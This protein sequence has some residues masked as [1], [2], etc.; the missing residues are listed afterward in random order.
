MVLAKLCCSVALEVTAGLAESNGSLLLGLYCQKMY[1]LQLLSRTSRRAGTDRRP[2]YSAKLRLWMTLTCIGHTAVAGACGEVVRKR[3]TDS[4]TDS[5]SNTASAC[6][7][8]SV[9]RICRLMRTQ[10]F[11]IRTPLELETDCDQQHAQHRSAQPQPYLSPLIAPSLRLRPGY[12]V[13]RSWHRCIAATDNVNLK[14]MANLFADRAN[15]NARKW[16]HVAT[17]LNGRHTAGS[18]I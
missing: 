1:Q 18:V 4:R 3:V 5:G 10:Y 7:R 6:G 15:V 11:G 2:T 17:M 14:H 9:I 16:P 8:G 13:Q 12:P